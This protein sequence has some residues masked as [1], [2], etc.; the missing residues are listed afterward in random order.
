MALPARRRAAG[1]RHVVVEAGGAQLGASG[2]GA[3][4]AGRAGAGG[5]EGE[6]DAG[7]AAAEDAP[8][9]GQLELLAAA[10]VYV[11]YPSGTFDEWDVL[12]FVDNSSALY[13]LAVLTALSLS[14]CL[15]SW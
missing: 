6:H 8:L 3:A 10:A 7:P 5:L 13:G 1:R 14:S 15:F 2:R 11:S 4:R 12:H 9:I